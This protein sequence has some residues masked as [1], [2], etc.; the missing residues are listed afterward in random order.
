MITDKQTIP[1]AN[2]FG[3]LWHPAASE[4]ETSCQSSSV[5]LTQVGLCLNRSMAL[6]G[7]FRPLELVLP[8]VFPVRDVGISV[9][10][11]AW[12]MRG[13]VV[14]LIMITLTLLYLLSY[15]I[16]IVTYGLSQNS[17]YYWTN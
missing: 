14:Y 2:R 16:L 9:F 11:W 13:H 1:S 17:S 10:G 8:G 3:I 5:G 6:S 7:A 12:W 15:I 4:K